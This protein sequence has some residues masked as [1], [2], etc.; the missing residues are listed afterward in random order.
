[1]E[2]GALAAQ[3]KGAARGHERIKHGFV[4]SNNSK[5]KEGRTSIGKRERKEER[6]GWGWGWVPGFVGLADGGEGVEEAGVG[7]VLELDDPQDDSLHAGEQ[8]LLVLL[9]R[10][11]RRSR[12]RR[13]RRH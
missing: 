10:R 13:R 9:R 1:M 11:R 8:R 12:S 2:E 5:R 4:W 6:R 3:G 7:V